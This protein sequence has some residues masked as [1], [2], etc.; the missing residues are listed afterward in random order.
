MQ[1]KE[2]PGIEQ[3]YQNRYSAD[4]A[5]NLSE[6][7]RYGVGESYSVEE[8][9][10]QY[11]ETGEVE[12]DGQTES[13]GTDAGLEF[14]CS[15]QDEDDQESRLRQAFDDNC[16][17]DNETQRYYGSSRNAA[18]PPAPY[19]EPVGELRDA[20]DQQTPAS[21][22]GDEDVGISTTQRY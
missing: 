11:P 20:D 5:E 18:D 19:V 17:G 3:T 1:Q 21:Y 6:P 9:Q 10:E 22:C 4:D 12:K 15:R 8:Q 7:Q 14:A 16:D 13:Y 2:Y